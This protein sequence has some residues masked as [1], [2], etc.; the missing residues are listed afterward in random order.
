MSTA[1]AP[2][3]G[4]TSRRHVA[5]FVI[6]SRWRGQ[7]AIAV[8]SFLGGAFEALFLVGVTQVAF[9]LTEGTDEFSL[10]LGVTVSLGQAIALLASVLVVR[11]LLAVTAVWLGARLAASIVVDI[12]TQLTN[13]FLDADWGLQ[14]GE[15]GGSLQELVTNYGNRMRTYWSAI[16][17]FTVAAANLIAMLVLA[18]AV[19]P[20]GAVVLMITV[21]GL[22]SLLRPLRRRLWRRSDQANEAG[23]RLA[24]GLNEA[25]DLGLELHVFGVQEAAKQRVVKQVRDEATST[26]RQSVLG[27]LVQPVYTGTAYLVLVLALVFVGTLETVD[28]AS[29]GAVMLIMLRSLGYGQATQH[30]LAS[31]SVGAPAVVTIQNELSRFRSQPRTDGS[32]RI[33]AIR[34]I[35]CRDVS[36]SYL[37]GKVV[38]EHVSLELEPPEVVGIIGP[39]GSGKSTLVQILLGL[40]EP[41]EGT[42]VVNGFDLRTIHRSDWV[43]RAT[44]VPQ[45]SSLIQGTVADNIRFLRSG[46]TDADVVRAAELANLHHEITALKEG[47]DTPLGAGGARLSGGQQQRL[48]IARAL[49]EQPDLLVLDEPT[50]ALDVRSEQ[51]IRS[52]LAGLR[53]AT[54]IVIIAHRLS[55]LDFCDRILVMQ[56]GQ[57]TAF[58]TPNALERDD[59][60]YREALR[61]SGMR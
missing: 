22:G 18:V 54:T 36:F 25:S 7:T 58:D 60:F 40:R 33:D 50:S 26:R 32:S 49:V 31:L 29:L 5:R 35:E 11:L 23:M 34:S 12:R 55:T 56:N 6:G 52:S 8:S 20:L 39:S 48:S 15:R 42:I 37:P 19:D 24:T 1:D 28:L 17:A 21:A 4:S 14:H 51:L 53:G 3:S 45:S 57:V 16:N 27:G 46:V 44:F 2:E 47:Y 9:G 61:L 59:E 30:A 10:A 43:R 13:A 38:L 41:D